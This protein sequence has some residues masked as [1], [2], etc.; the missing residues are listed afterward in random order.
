ME[1]DYRP[2]GKAT[3]STYFIPFPPYHYISYIFVL[4]SLFKVLPTLKLSLYIF[5]T[6]KDQAE[7]INSRAN[8]VQQNAWE[9]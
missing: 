5:S 9:T 2:F 7:G 6:R 4:A 3:V 1:I 8:M